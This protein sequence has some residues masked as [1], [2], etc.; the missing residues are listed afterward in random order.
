VVTFPFLQS[1]GDN[2]EYRPVHD[3]LNRFWSALNVPQLDLLNTFTNLPREKTTVNRYDAH[4]NEF[5]N[6]LA[7]KAIESFLVEQMS[8]NVTSPAR[9]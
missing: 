7:A 4:P 8:T 6:A 2:Y 5:A 1:L 9:P 3:E